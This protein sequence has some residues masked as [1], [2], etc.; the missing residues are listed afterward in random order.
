MQTGSKPARDEGENP[1]W[2]NS[3]NMAQAA[4]QEMGR[5]D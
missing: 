2:G 5:F 1:I 3:G 4:D